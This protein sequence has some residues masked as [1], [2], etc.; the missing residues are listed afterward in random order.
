MRMLNDRGLLHDDLGN[1][2]LASENFTESARLAGLLKDEGRRFEARNNAA[3]SYLK[4]GQPLQ[5]VPLF[6]GILR[7]QDAAGVWPRRMAARNNLATT[8]A[9]LGDHERA[10]DLYAEVVT[11]MGDH[12]SPSLWIALTGL[13]AAYDLCAQERPEL[14]PVGPDHM[15]RCHRVGEIQLAPLLRRPRLVQEPSA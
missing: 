6:R 13:A 9:S 15:V 7:E 2:A 10:R 14:R 11:M 8:Y 3:A 1:Y 12:Y 5:A 4:R